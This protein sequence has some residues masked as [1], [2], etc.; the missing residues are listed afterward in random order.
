MKCE[1]C[2][3]GGVDGALDQMGDYVCVDC[4]ADGSANYEGRTANTFSPAPSLFDVDYPNHV[5][6]GFLNA[7]N[8]HNQSPEEEQES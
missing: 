3:Q 6:Q 4:W 2:G 5:S 1:I 8:R 7:C